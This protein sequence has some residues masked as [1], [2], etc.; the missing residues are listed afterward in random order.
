MPEF[1]SAAERKAAE[2][3][4]CG[5]TVILR[6]SPIT[7]V[8]VHRQLRSVRRKDA[9]RPNSTKRKHGCQI[10]D[11]R[12]NHKDRIVDST[13]DPIHSPVSGKIH[14]N[15]NRIDVVPENA[16]QHIHSLRRHGQQIIDRKRIVIEMRVVSRNGR[17]RLRA[18]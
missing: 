4:K 6:D 10:H 16:I 18:D 5:D 12:R 13:R 11:R 8:V 3:A 2:F 17:G 1:R 7:C 9:Q 15:A 14:G